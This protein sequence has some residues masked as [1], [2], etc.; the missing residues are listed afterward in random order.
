TTG[1]VQNNQARVLV[2]RIPYNNGSAVTGPVT[3]SNTVVT[4]SNNGTTVNLPHTAIDD[5]FT[6][7]LLPPG[8][9][10]PSPSPSPSAPGS[11]SVLRNVNANRCLDVPSQSTTNG[12]QL[13]LWDCNGQTNQS[14]TYTSGK[15]LQVYGNK[16]LDANGQGTSN[17]TQVIIWDCNGQ[18]NQQ[19]NV[20]ADGTIT[21]VQSGLC[22]EAS[23]FGTANGTKVQLW[24]CTG[25]T[26]Q[27]WTR[28]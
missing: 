26:S 2:E 28:S 25:T 12:T 8:G 3:V 20:N 21:G 11:A 14:W 16:C 18:A 22:V 9:G 13:Q 27:K 6:I 15:A 19:W 17:G 23:N 10:N 1:I 24:S 5:T 7:T 4:L